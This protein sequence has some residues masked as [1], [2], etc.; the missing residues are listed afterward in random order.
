MDYFS[1]FLNIEPA[2]YI[3]DKSHLAI[4]YNSFYTFFNSICS[5]FVEDFYMYVY[6]IFVYSFLVMS[7]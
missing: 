3:W 5:Y 4:S 6:E 7:F 1:W 2:L